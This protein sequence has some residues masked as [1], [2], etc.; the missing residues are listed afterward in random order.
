MK[1]NSFW[2]FPRNSSLSKSSWIHSEI[3]SET[4]L[5]FRSE[6]PPSILCSFRNSIWAYPSKFFLVFFKHSSRCVS[7]N[8]FQDSCCSFCDFSG[9]SIWDYSWGSLISSLWYFSSIPPEFRTDTSKDSFRNFS[10]SFG[11][12]PLQEL[13][14]RLIL[15]FLQNCSSSFRDY[16]NILF[17]NVFRSFSSGGNP[18]KIL[19]T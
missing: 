8:L 4:S 1:R 15:E 16:P 18:K 3:P 13:F 19:K 5:G 6:I 12:P 14:P 7:R 11:N 10:S 17:W 9:N 2:D